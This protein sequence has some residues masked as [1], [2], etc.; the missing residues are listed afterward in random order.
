MS[1]RHA[2]R[3]GPRTADQGLRAAKT[4]LFAVAL[5]PLAVLAWN[6]FT[7][8]LGA[9]PI[10]TVERFTGWWAITLLTA[11]L[12]VTP[13]RL[14]TG[15]TA[16]ARLR[17]MLGLSAFFWACLHVSAYVGLD[18]F[19]AVRDI[20]KDVA[21]RPYITVGFATFLLL[22]PLAATSTDA[23]IRR[24]GGARWRKLHRLAYLAAG[25]AVLHFLWLVKADITEPLI[26]AS[27]LAL[28]LAARLRHAERPADRPDLAVDAPR[29]PTSRRAA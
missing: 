2:S 11:T 23:M 22:L 8:G 19:F 16:V 18:Q 20:V 28:L 27:I 7:D 13:I 25:G 26:Y 10:E 21:K 3:T 6:A 4:G 12:A 15:W 1:A 24:V 17:R 14:L 5:T 29:A 9:N